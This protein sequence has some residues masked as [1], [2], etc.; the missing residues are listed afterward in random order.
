MRVHGGDR[1]RAELDQ[2]LAA[3]GPE[4]R[5]VLAPARRVGR[6]ARVDLGVGVALE[7]AEAALAQ[8]GVGRD[9]QIDHRGDR[10][11]GV[12]GAHQVAR[13]DRLDAFA[14]QRLGGTARLPAAARAEGGV[15]LALHA[16]LGVPLGLAV[17]D[18]DDA[19]RPPS[20]R[21]FI[22]SRRLSV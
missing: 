4:R 20:A 9:R 21:S 2:A 7:D 15:E 1:A 14:G 3:F 13:E 6:P 8:A 16:H 19:R 22:S 18:R 5:I 10:L 17:A 12:E 11:R